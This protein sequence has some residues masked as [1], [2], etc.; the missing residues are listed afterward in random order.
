MFIGTTEIFQKCSM[1]RLMAKKMAHV[2]NM[3]AHAWRLFW[4]D[5]YVHTDAPPIKTAPNYANSHRWGFST[6]LSTVFKNVAQRQS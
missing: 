4:P 1:F 2:T 5:V 6:P 3:L